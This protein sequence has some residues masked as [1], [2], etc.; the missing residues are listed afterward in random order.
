[1]VRNEV[2]RENSEDNIANNSGTYMDKNESNSRSINQA[3]DQ[4]K[5]NSN[6]SFFTEVRF[7]DVS[8]KESES[9]RVKQSRSEETT[10]LKSSFWAVSLFHHSFIC[11]IR[12]N[13]INS[14]H[15]WLRTAWSYKYYS[16]KLCTQQD[17][18]Q[19]LCSRQMLFWRLW[20]LNSTCFIFTILFL[21][22]L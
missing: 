16:C 6:N 3:V 18:I 19:P 21:F 11:R 10:L 14:V 4:L 1:M 7:D 15:M 13:L 5:R 9:F 12:L 20:Y 22:F 2:S 8:L 17:F